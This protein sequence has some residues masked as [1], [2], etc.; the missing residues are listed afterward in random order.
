MVGR[1]SKAERKGVDHLD[2][3]KEPKQGVSFL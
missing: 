3:E 1:A 2:V